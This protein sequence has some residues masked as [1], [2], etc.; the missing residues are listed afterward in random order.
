MQNVYNQIL[1]QICINLEEISNL[2]LERE[3]S[4]AKGESE[5]PIDIDNLLLNMKTKY[6]TTEQQVS[7]DPSNNVGETA[8]SGEVNFF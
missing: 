6:T 3:E 8:D 4:N 1:D 7:H 5:I 2:M